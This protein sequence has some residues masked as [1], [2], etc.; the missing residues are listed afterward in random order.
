MRKIMINQIAENT[1]SSDLNFLDLEQL[2][3]VEF[4]SECLEYPIESALLLTE[5]SGSGWRAASG[6]EQT[7]RLFFDQPRTI[8]HIFLIFDEPQQSRTQEFVLLWLMDKES[9]YR[10]ILRQQYHF[11]PP[12]TTREIEHYEVRLNQLKVLELR[13]IPDISGGEAC[14]RLKQLRLA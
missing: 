7:I 3:Q 1:P 6:G 2:A 4:T 12:D 8:E 10:E 5:D 9:S 13:I 11:S 14:A